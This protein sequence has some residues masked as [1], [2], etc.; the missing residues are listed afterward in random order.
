MMHKGIQINETTKN[1]T[2]ETHT[3]AISSHQSVSNKNV[4]YRKETVGSSVEPD[5]SPSGDGNS[6]TEGQ[7]CG[8]TPSAFW[9]LLPFLCTMLKV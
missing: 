9:C 1:N 6:G 2:H 5:T 3:Q 7:A 8:E 4:Y